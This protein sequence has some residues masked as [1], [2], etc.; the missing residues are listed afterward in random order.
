MD[1]RMKMVK[2][3]L[4]IIGILA[5][6]GLLIFFYLGSQAQNIASGANKAF[7]TVLMAALSQTWWIYLVIIAVCIVLYFLIKLI[8][9]KKK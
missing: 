3:A 6:L 8:F 4:I 1:R 2:Y 9:G 5:V 7:G